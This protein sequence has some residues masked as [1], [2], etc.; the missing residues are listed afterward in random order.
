LELVGGKGRVDGGSRDG[1][2]HLEHPKNPA[3]KNRRD[4]QKKGSKTA[5]PPKMAKNP[6]TSRKSHFYGEMLGVRGQESKIDPNPPP[7]APPA[8][9]NSLL[10]N[11]QKT[12]KPQ[13]TGPWDFEIFAKQSGFEGAPLNSREGCG[14]PQNHLA[15]REK[16]GHFLL[17][18][19]WVFEVLRNLKNS[20]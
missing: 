2:H 11:S 3:S 20:Q 5:K 18:K 13:K 16:R 1:Y 14:T 10:E 8:R 7:P 12:P 17:S 19:I 9:R 4:P 15:L 6:I